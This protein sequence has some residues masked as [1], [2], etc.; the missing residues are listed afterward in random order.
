MD[1]RSQKEDL[2]RGTGATAFWS[3]DF[4]LTL[5]TLCQPF[6][7][8]CGDSAG[9][10]CS[11][12]GQCLSMAELALAANDNGDATDYTYGVD[13]NNP[14]TWDGHRIY[15][16]RCD[17]G[18]EGYDCSLRVC[19]K[20]DDP[21]TY[22]QHA[23]VHLLQCEATNG[24]FTLSFRQSV[25][26]PIPY[27]ASLAELSAALNGLPTIR[28]GLSLSFSSGTHACTGSGSNSINATFVSV[29]GKVPVIK[30]NTSSLVND[31]KGGG[32]G[33]GTVTITES[34]QG[35]TENDVCS[36]RG[37]CDTATGVCEC[38]LGFSSSD[39]RNHE[40]P[41]GECGYRVPQTSTLYSAAA[42]GTSTSAK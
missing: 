39:G 27:N 37:L 38:F 17:P 21:G 14:R 20:G 32:E 10:I 28:G 15:G 22:G 16:C 34:V 8:G 13:P 1:G 31:N 36:N 2:L 23:A 11:G 40:G 9:E 3:T 30:T 4:A 6:A 19:P 7:V 5:S 24:S 26:G 41:L 35:T 12:H 33:S 29:F 42:G 18:F 25:T